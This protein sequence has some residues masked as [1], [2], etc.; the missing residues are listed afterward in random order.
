MSEVMFLVKRNL[1][2]YV[3]AAEIVE[4][5]GRKTAAGAA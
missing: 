1:G 4:L 3:N 2:E 5:C